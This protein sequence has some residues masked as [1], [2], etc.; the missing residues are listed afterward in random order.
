MCTEEDPRCV[1]RMR[2]RL[3]LQ[4]TFF[5]SSTMHFDSELKEVVRSTNSLG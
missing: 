4:H 5:M 3:V 2:Q 1:V